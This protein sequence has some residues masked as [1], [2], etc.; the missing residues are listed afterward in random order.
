MQ[1][2]ITTLTSIV[3]LLGAIAKAAPTVEVKNDI[4]YVYLTEE[5]LTYVPEGETALNTTTSDL[6]VRGGQLRSHSYPPSSQL[7]LPR[8]IVLSYIT[9]LPYSVDNFGCGGTCYVFATPA[10]SIEISEETNANPRPS[11]SLISAGGCSNEL[12]HQS[13][14]VNGFSS[15]TNTNIGGWRSA[16]LYY[17]CR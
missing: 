1:F 13:A 12:G 3:A 11:A 14:G 9:N 6:V 8:A 5:D 17:N 16:Y 7:R 15:C 2:S 4:R 10:Q